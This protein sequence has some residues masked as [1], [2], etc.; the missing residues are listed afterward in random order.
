MFFYGINS[1]AYLAMTAIVVT[2]VTPRTK[3]N[4]KEDQ[5]KWQSAD[6]KLFP[7]APQ[8]PLLSAK[9]FWS[10]LAEISKSTFIFSWFVVTL[11]QNV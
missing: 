11:E 8:S 9:E 5:L 1:V 10:P 2:T 4:M 3:P 6:E 7:G